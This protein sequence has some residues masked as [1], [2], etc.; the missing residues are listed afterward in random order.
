M[1]TIQ[2]LAR[3]TT[4]VAFLSVFV[5]ATTALAALKTVVLATTTGTQDSGLLDGV[6]TLFEKDSGCQIR[7]ISVGSGQAVKKERAEVLLVRLSDTGKKHSPL[8]A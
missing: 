4:L 6:V 5:W 3:I 1:S 8:G 2:I 7:F